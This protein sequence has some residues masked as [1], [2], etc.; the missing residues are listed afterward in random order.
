MF[1]FSTRD[2]TLDHQ[3]LPFGPWYVLSAPK[4]LILTNSTR[5]RFYVESL[6]R[7]EQ[8]RRPILWLCRPSAVWSFWGF[9]FLFYLE[10]FLM[11]CLFP[12]LSC[13]RVSASASFL[14][15]ESLFLSQFCVVFWWFPVF[16]LDIW[17]V[18]KSRSLDFWYCL[19]LFLANLPRV[20]VAINTTDWRFLRCWCWHRGSHRSSVFGGSAILMLQ[21]NRGRSFIRRKKNMI[22]A[23]C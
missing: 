9:S 23:I 14:C 5:I 8:T 16:F 2:S 21:E 12:V 18:P 17:L 11:L 19:I 13:F 4:I 6:R 3:Y 22:M 7:V 15:R 1:Y 10:G 20:F